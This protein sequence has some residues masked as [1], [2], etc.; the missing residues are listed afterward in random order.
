MMLMLEGIGG[1]IDQLR[2]TGE[3]RPIDLEAGAGKP[4][5]RPQEVVGITLVAMQAGDSLTY[6]I[7]DDALE[8]FTEHG[9]GAHFH[10]DNGPIVHQAR[11]GLAETHRLTQVGHPIAGIEGRSF[12]AGSGDARM[13]GDLAARRADPFEGGRESIGQAAHGRGVRRIID[14]HGAGPDTRL[15]E[16]DDETLELPEIAGDNTGAGTVVHGKV[17]PLPARLAQPVPQLVSRGGDR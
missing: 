7:T 8:S 4:P 17:Q 2:R 5:N 11:D 14:L 6:P 9:V 10:E 3:S 13:E 16:V 15:V 12:L 1:E